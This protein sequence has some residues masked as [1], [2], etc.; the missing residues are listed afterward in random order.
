MFVRKDDN[1]ESVKE[2]L[3]VYKKQTAPLIDYYG[4][5]GKLFAVNADLP[6]EQVFDEIL[7]VVK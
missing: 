4:K 7:K 1:E 2:R 6:I 3:D 5:Q